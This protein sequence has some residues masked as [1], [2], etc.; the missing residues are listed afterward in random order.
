MM[1][2]ARERPRVAAVTVLGVAALV[3]CGAA[4]GALVAGGGQRAPAAAQVRLASADQANREQARQLDAAQD[5][6]ARSRALAE[7]L[8]RR[9]RELRTANGRLRRALRHAR[10]TA[11]RQGQRRG[12]GRE[13]QG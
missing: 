5:Q 9:S 8:A 12:A 7:R 6:A 10:I 1:R 11:R 4:L 3:L 13:R 2:A